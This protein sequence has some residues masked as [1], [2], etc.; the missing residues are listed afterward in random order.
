MAYVIQEESKGRKGWRKKF[1]SSVVT[2]LEEALKVWNKGCAIKGCTVKAEHGNFR[3]AVQAL[4]K[5]WTGDDKGTRDAD[6]T[7]P[8]KFGGGTVRVPQKIA[9]RAKAKEVLDTLCPGG[10]LDFWQELFSDDTVRDS[11]EEKAFEN[12]EIDDLPEYPISH[13]KRGDG[14]IKDT[15]QGH[16]LPAFN[17]LRN[18]DYPKLQ[19]SGSE[20]R[21]YGFVCEGDRKKSKEFLRNKVKEGETLGH[22]P[23]PLR[24]LGKDDPVNHISQ[25]AKENSADNDKLDHLHDRAVKNPE[26]AGKCVSWQ[27]RDLVVKLGKEKVALAE[28]RTQ[29][30]AAVT[31]YFAELYR[32]HEQGGRR[33]HDD[34]KRADPGQ[35][36][37]IYGRREEKLLDWLRNQ[38]KR[39]R[40]NHSQPEDD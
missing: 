28:F 17:H 33:I 23:A 34:I 18:T 10:T 35:T 27:I 11:A 12:D 32:D 38:H 20:S 8:A 16:N 13:T 21:P 15:V 9:D 39:G 4:T 30:H 6:L 36:A 22:H 40:F 25:D 2:D 19:K 5:Q 26:A 7:L 37:K 29:I 24:W 1:P 31:D 14:N 3:G